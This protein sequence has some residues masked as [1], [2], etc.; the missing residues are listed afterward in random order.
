[1][2]KSVQESVRLPFDLVSKIDKEYVD[3]GLFSS[4][5]DFVSSAIRYYYENALY[6]FA[7]Y[8]YTLLN[9]RREDPDVFRKM[10][11]T[12]EVNTL[13]AMQIVFRNEKRLNKISDYEGN[14]EKIT[15]LVR[16]P[17]ELVK[18]YVRF[19]HESGIYNNK[20]EFYYYAIEVY[21]DAQY[22]VGEILDCIDHRDVRRLLWF[23]DD[24][25]FLARRS[26]ISE[27]ESDSFEDD[28]VND[29]SWDDWLDKYDGPLPSLHEW[30]K[31]A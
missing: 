19:I 4:R 1:M 16:L 31:S 2:V 25:Y 27:S 7:K 11:A 18:C 30:K 6:Q 5:A 17:P 8:T 26:P 28:P 12:E 14:G 22:Y 10:G 13:T 9:L 24:S 15:V 23:N 21:L 29:T 20:A 3:T